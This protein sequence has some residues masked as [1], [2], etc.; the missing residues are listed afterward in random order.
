MKGWVF[1]Y[2][3]GSRAMV[4]W[5]WREVRIPF[6][7]YLYVDSSCSRKLFSLLPRLK[8]PLKVKRVER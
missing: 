6:R 5:L 1:D 7:P 8:I 2:Y 3:P 4:V